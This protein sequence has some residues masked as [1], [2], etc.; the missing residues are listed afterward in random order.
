MKPNFPS[1]LIRYV[2]CLLVCYLANISVSQA[3]ISGVSQLHNGTDYCVSGNNYS[4]RYDNSPYF[5]N[6]N[7]TY[8]INGYV[9]SGYYV[10][11]YVAQVTTGGVGV[12]SS[13]LY[14]DSKTNLNSAPLHFTGNGKVILPYQMNYAMCL[15]LKNTQTNDIYIFVSSNNRPE[16][17]SAGVPPSPTPPPPPTSCSINNSNTLTVDLGT[18]ER[19]KL[20]TDPAAGSVSQK[21]IPIPVNC[22][23]GAVSVKMNLSYTAITVAGKSV[24]KSSTNGLGV[25]IIYNDQ[26]LAPGANTPLQFNE[27]ANQLNLSFITVRDPSITLADI[28]AG[29]FSASATLV[30]TQQ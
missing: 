28:S 16:A 25:G 27:G 2:L 8:N 24:V 19:A 11:V 7:C 1:V 20:P 9:P 14:I 10:V 22:T 17:C 3:T 6:S 5:F 29:A 12:L 13:S 21:T 18:L 26:V 4:V 30:L 23:G 15:G